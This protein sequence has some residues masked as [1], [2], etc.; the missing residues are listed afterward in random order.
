MTLPGGRFVT[1][2][3][4][5]R[6]NVRLTN[7]SNNLTTTLNITGTV[8]TSTDQYKNNIFTFDGRNLVG[9][10]GQP[11]LVLTI[12]NFHFVSDKYGVPVTLL[13]GTGQLVSICSLLE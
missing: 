9:D 10:P 8:K 3:I 5:P 13:N 7:L 1:I 4:S 11:G 2:A 6:L 12:G